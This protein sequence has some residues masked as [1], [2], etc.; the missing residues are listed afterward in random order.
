[1]SLTIGNKEYCWGSI[2]GHLLII[3]KNGGY[4]IDRDIQQI[5]EEFANCETIGNPEWVDQAISGLKN[6]DLPDEFTPTITY[7]LDLL[8]SIKLS[9]I[10]EVAK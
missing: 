2:Y 9:I 1:M 7:L 3:N 6:L 4:P 5:A 10:S 8:D